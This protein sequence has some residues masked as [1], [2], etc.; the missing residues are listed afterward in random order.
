MSIVFGL[1]ESTVGL[2]LPM[3]LFC[4]FDV[5]RMAEKPHAFWRVC[6]QATLRF[7]PMDAA[8]SCASQW[9]RSGLYSADA[10]PS[11]MSYSA[12]RV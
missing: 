10:E 4:S 11:P 5:G 6:D 1:A 12:C 3:E 9:H 2:A 7:G 8:T